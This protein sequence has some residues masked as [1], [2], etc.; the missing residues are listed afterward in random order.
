M[1]KTIRKFV[2]ERRRDVH[3]RRRQILEEADTKE[4]RDASEIPE[5]PTDPQL[6]EPPV[7]TVWGKVKWYSPIKRYGF[8]EL[9]D[10]SGDAFLHATALAGMGMT[11][12]R[13]GEALEF[14]VAPGQPG[15]QVTEVISVDSSTAAP[16]RPP[17]RRSNWQDR[18]PLEAC[19]QAMGMVKWYNAARGFGFIVMDGGEE[20]FVHASA[21]KRAG[22][23]GLNEGQRVRRN[24]GSEGTGSRLNPTRLTAPCRLSTGR[25]PPSVR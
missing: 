12:L 22:I 8:V 25:K 16:S 4:A 23:A 24:G 14:R 7:P 2:L 21:L 20:I 5:Q 15:P 13:P 17:P 11:T 9:S 19:V 6:D 18:Q 3:R 1:L 10:G